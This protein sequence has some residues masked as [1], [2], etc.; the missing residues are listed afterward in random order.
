MTCGRLAA[1]IRCEASTLFLTAPRIRLRIT[2]RTATTSKAR[3]P[4]RIANQTTYQTRPL[5]TDRRGSPSQVPRGDLERS[6]HSRS[7]HGR[8]DGPN[9]T[10]APQHLKD[11]LGH[12]AYSPDQSRWRPDPER[13]DTAKPSADLEE[14]LFPTS[15]DTHRE[16]EHVNAWHVYGPCSG[17]AREA[18]C[19]QGNRTSRAHPQ[20]L[21]PPGT[22]R[23]EARKA[24][25]RIHVVVERGLSVG[26]RPRTV[27]PRRP[28][29]H[30][31]ERDPAAEHAWILPV[32]AGRHA[33]PPLAARPG[34]RHRLMNIK[35]SR[36]ALGRGR[37]TGP[38]WTVPPTDPTRVRTALNRRHQDRP[39]RRDFGR[40]RAFGS[41]RW[42]S[43]PGARL[44]SGAV[45]ASDRGGE[46]CESR[47]GEESGTIRSIRAR[48]SAV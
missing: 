31:L 25:E 19:S 11:N 46:R 48:W 20:S 21:P 42:G 41:A 39:T 22:V 35:D 47:G 38:Q 18:R 16:A 15:Y 27:S 30:L 26:G 8:C 29:P 37:T 14:D 24:C 40:P 44:R 9:N 10:V 6:P 3:K 1:D 45:Q 23:R 4:D 28:R 12:D 33:A 43:D 17:D 36:P 32:R 7:A 34:C 5:A 2:R 13:P